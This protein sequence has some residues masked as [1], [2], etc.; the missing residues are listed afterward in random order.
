MGN[1]RCSRPA[2]ATGE[3]PPPEGLEPKQNTLPWLLSP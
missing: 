3:T 1:Q 2:D